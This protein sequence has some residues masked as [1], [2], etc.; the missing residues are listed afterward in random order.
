MCAYMPVT[1][2]GE[3]FLSF[4]HKAQFERRFNGTTQSLKYI[5]STW[6]L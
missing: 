2:E 6:V 3:V 1:V 5:P 4:S